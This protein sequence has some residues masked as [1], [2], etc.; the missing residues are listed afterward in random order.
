MIIFDEETCKKHLDMWLSADLAVAKGQSYTI[1]GRTL[2]RVNSGEI[3]RN[4]ELW[5]G[6]LRK[7]QNKSSGPRTFTIIPKG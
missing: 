1:G 2:T 6:R 3:N 4:L 7:I 5:A